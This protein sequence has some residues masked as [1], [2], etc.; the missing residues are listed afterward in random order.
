[1]GTIS[2][3]FRGGNSAVQY[4]EVLSLLRCAAHASP[5]RYHRSPLS[6]FRDHFGDKVEEHH[7]WMKGNS[8]HP[9][10]GYGYAKDD[11]GDCRVLLSTRAY[12]RIVSSK[13]KASSISRTIWEIIE[14]HPNTVRLGYSMQVPSQHDKTT[15]DCPCLCRPGVT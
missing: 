4:A 5:Y 7:A 15:P 11:G 10:Y 8:K 3:L 6:Q 13:V 1:M 14:D 12:R 9:V 2:I